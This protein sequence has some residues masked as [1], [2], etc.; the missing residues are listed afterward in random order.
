MENFE[1]V[2]Y[3]QPEANEDLRL[4]DESL[5][6]LDGAAKWAKIVSIMGLSLFGVVIIIVLFSLVLTP[7]VFGILGFLFYVVILGVASLPYI[8]MY[9]F[10]TQLKEALY[11]KR[12]ETLEEG[13]GYLKSFF[14]IIGIFMI[15]I[16]VIY[17][18]IF[19]MAI[20][21]GRLGD[22]F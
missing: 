7:H 21:L 5:F 8:F 15:I 22:L 1:P 14:L 13:L 9:K 12:S 3:E 18:L 4:T 6:N 2:S 19:L 20:I 11:T 17:I 16:I 10:A